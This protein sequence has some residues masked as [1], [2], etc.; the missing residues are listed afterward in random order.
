[1]TF[2]FS[3]ASGGEDEI[4]QLQKVL[5]DHLDENTETDPSLV[6]SRK[7]YIA[8]WFRD[9]TMETEKAIKSQKDEDSSE[10][11]H[12]AKD[13]E[14]TGQ[15]MHRA[16][17]RKK[18]LRSIIKTAPSQFSTLRMSSDTVDY[19]D[20]CLIVRYLASMRPF[21]QSFDIYLTQ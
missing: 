8:Q 15:I 19:E 11:A 2:Y 17:S 16:E 6:F 12:H 9:T 5:L 10:G 3:Q 18:F 1:I 21:A 7:F 20:A 14:T 4:Q 13:V